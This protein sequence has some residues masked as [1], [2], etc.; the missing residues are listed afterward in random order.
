ML[1]LHA[2]RYVHIIRRCF[3]F[4]GVIVLLFGYRCKYQ[5]NI[6][7]WKISSWRDKIIIKKQK[8]SRIRSAKKM[9]LRI[10]KN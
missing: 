9:S 5:Y 10:R 7:V 8:E 3:V 6:P 2:E 1:K 4:N